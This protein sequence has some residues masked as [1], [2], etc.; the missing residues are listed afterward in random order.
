MGVVYFGFLTNL[1][2]ALGGLSYL[3]ITAKRKI[4]TNMQ[5]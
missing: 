5:I 2:F 4:Y 3:Q 1:S